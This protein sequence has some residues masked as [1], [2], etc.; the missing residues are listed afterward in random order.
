M[1]KRVGIA[2]ATTTKVTGRPPI[3]VLIAGATGVGKSTTAVKIANEHSFA[4]LL[5][6]DAIREI[7]RVVNTTDDSALHRSSFSR[8]ESGDAVLDWQDT[9][10]AVEAGIL[11]TIERARREGIDLILEGVH[12]EPSSRLLRSWRDSGGI[13]VGIVMH[14]EDE[15]QHTSFL[16]Q[17][18]SHSF[19]NADRY[20]SA[21]PRIR[22]IQESLKDKARLVDW[23]TLDP[24]RVKD[25]LERVNHW[26]DLAWNEWRKRN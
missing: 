9:C 6:T 24:T 7:M 2:G 8:G 13:A 5:S 18:E 25:S 26:L 3:L 23:N 16:K 10:K 11:A 20:I 17:R 12:L 1:A 19:R 4:R 21:L 22:S 15:A 14:V